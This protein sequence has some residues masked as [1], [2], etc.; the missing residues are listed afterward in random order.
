[1]D[2]G[3]TGRG[4]C[5]QLV[6]QAPAIGRRIDCFGPEKKA[7][8]CVNRRPVSQPDHRRP[9]AYAGNGGE[10]GARARADGARRSCRACMWVRRRRMLMR[11]GQAAALQRLAALPMPA[12]AVTRTR[13]MLPSHR[14]LRR[15]R[16][17]SLA[18]ARDGDV[19]EPCVCSINRLTGH[20][21][22]CCRHLTS[23]LGAWGRPS[24]ARK[25]RVCA[26]SAR[27][28][29]TRGIS[30]CALRPSLL[31]RASLEHIKRREHASRARN[32]EKIIC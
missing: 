13:R 29:S 28:D 23:P 12:R 7:P 22:G 17:Q 3:R 21:R 26:S 1:M 10:H 9:P 30:G 19:T 14:Q 11:D 5:W 8:H 32:E 20:P 31:R 24:R 18:P 2:R 15:R 25:R 16:H 6:H 27:M 4:P